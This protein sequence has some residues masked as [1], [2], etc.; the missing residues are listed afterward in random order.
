MTNDILVILNIL[1]LKNLIS[2]EIENF[3]DKLF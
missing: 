3:N 1:H 2:A